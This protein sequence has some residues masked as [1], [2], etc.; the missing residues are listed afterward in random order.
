M[1]PL[2]GFDW[3]KERFLYP[4]PPLDRPGQKEEQPPE[5]QA[6]LPDLSSPSPSPRPTDHRPLEKDPQV[7]QD[8]CD[9]Q[10][11]PAQPG[12]GVEPAVEI[13]T[14]QPESQSE[15][16][17]PQ[18]A[19]DPDQALAPAHGDHGQRGASVLLDH[20]EAGVAEE[21]SRPLLSLSREND[22]S[23]GFAVVGGPTSGRRR[24]PGDAS[25]DS[26]GGNGPRPR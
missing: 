15:P 19:Q 3:H 11:Q 13:E 5:G 18:P 14:T 1:T 6:F 10:Q 2:S 16:V 8:D 22:A 17:L 26:E 21:G 7:V 9:P 24:P 20:I 25:R 12:H 4:Q 23:L